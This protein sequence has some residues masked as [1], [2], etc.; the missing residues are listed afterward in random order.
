MEPYPSR[1]YYSVSPRHGLRGKA[2][3]RSFCKPSTMLRQAAVLA[4]RRTVGAPTLPAAMRSAPLAVRSQGSASL[5]AFGAMTEHKPE[6]SVARP[7]KGASRTEPDAE[8]IEEPSMLYMYF[9]IAI[10]YGASLWIGTKY[11]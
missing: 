7:F 11:V 3:S 10:P 1:V 2:T 6:T 9:L 5:R 8:Y 4:A